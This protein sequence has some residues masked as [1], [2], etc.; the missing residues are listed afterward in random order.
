MKYYYVN[1]EAQSNGDHE[2]HTQD[3]KWLPD[4]LN[5]EDLG[6]FTNCNDAVKKAKETYPKADGCFYCSRECHKQ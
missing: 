3:C 5:R 1:K 4:V 2:V 6:F